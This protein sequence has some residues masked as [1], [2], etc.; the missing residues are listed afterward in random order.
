MKRAIHLL[1]LVILLGSACTPRTSL[2]PYKDPALPVETRLEDLLA[3]MTLDEKIGQM[4]QVEMGSIP[5]AYLFRPSEVEKYFIGSILSGGNSGGFTTLADWT[6]LEK[7]Y[8]ADA[9]MTRLGIPCC[10]G[11]TRYTALGMSTAP[12][13]FPTT[14]AWEPRAT[15]SWC[16]RSGR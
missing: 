16:A 1:L 11:W 14:S 2:T 12:R 8:Q 9:L 15:R 7:D 5:S 10:S 13:S 4:T 3:R 6:R